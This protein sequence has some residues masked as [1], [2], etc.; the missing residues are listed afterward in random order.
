[1]RQHGRLHTERG[2]LSVQDQSIIKSCP[3]CG[4][5]FPFR[6]NQ[7]QKQYC[8][9]KC[10]AIARGKRER[11]VDFVPCQ[12]C[13]K[14]YHPKEANRATYCS[15]ECYFAAIKAKPKVKT[16]LPAINC[17]QCGNSFVPA[18][19]AATLCSAECKREDARIKC[20]DRNRIKHGTFGTVTKS[21]AYCGAEFTAEKYGS[22]RSYCSQS[23]RD[24][25]Y[26]RTEIAKVAHRGVKSRRRARLVG[27]TLS[28]VS[29]LDVLIRDRWIC[30]ICGRKINRKVSVP[31]PDAATIDHIIPLARGG[32]HSMANLQAAHF[33]CNA[34]KS[35]QGGGQLRLSI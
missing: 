24:K 2:N 19:R 7:P 27:A 13:G 32:A 26:R 30:A 34:T 10:S 35:D 15:R 4:S 23:C 12:H 17:A 5:T 3:Q 33:I 9:P 16:V 22:Q 20:R 6:S 21:C 31:H 25:A 8:S 18:T 29:W 28:P 14:N 11:L 1:M